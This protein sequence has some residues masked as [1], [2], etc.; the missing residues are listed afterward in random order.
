MLKRIGLLVCV[1][2]FLMVCGLAMAEDTGFWDNYDDYF[3]DRY[4]DEYPDYTTA[5]IMDDPEYYMYYEDDVDPVDVSFTEESIPNTSYLFNNEWR[6]KEAKTVPVFGSITLPCNLE[7]IMDYFGVKDQIWNFA[8][9]KT[10]GYSWIPLFRV[11]FRCGSFLMPDTES[12]VSSALQSKN[13]VLRIK[14]GIVALLDTFMYSGDGTDFTEFV[15]NQLGSPK[16]ILARGDQLQ[17]QGYGYC[18]YTLCYQYD[19]LWFLVEMV[20]DC[21]GDTGNPTV[22][23]MD[24]ISF[25]R[26][27][28]EDF[29]EWLDYDQIIY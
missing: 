8:P 3:A 27:N 2:V 6:N 17:E 15:L 10:I 20:E 26:M 11:S 23:W 13:Y 19:D 24:E 21:S 4:N 29:M 25:T 14:D 7:E 9:E 28:P 5:T 22:Q 12:D 16:C 1:V 18:N